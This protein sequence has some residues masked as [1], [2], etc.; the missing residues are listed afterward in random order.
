M[1]N[2][3]IHVYEPVDGRWVSPTV[4]EHVA[5]LTLVRKDLSSRWVDANWASLSTYNERRNKAFLIAPPGYLS[6]EIDG[7]IPGMPHV[8]ANLVKVVIPKLQSDICLKQDLDFSIYP[9]RPWPGLPY[10]DRVWMALGRAPDGPMYDPQHYEHIWI[11]RDD[12]DSLGDLMDKILAL[13]A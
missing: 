4:F 11:V 3:I 13:M 6:G 12:I 2:I 8:V 9:G 7:L 10:M 5:K 1:A